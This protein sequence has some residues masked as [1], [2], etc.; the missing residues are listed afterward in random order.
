MLKEEASWS[1][2]VVQSIASGSIM[3]TVATITRVN[4]K[5]DATSY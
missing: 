4:I 2:L 1:M 3:L 5:F